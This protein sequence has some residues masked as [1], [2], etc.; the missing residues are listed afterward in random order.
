MKKLIDVIRE[1]EASKVAVGHFNISNLE[2]FWAVVNGAK[3]LN[4]PVI[5]GV[6]EGERDFMGVKQVKALVGTLQ[7]VGREVYLNADHT[8][9]FDRVKEVLDLGYNAAIIDGA[10]KSFEE[11]I[12]MTKACI[13]YKNS[14][15][16]E[17]L[18]EAELGFIG[19]S[20]QLLDE[21]P[22]GAQVNDEMMTKPEEAA[23][24]VQETG[25]DL[26]AP[27]VGNVHG[28]V[29]SGLEPRLNIDRIREIRAAAGVPLVLHGASGNS[30]E[31]ISAAIDAGISV[32]H[33][34]TEVRL[35][36]KQGLQKFLLDNPD[37][38]A[39]YKYL[40]AARQE[41]QSVVEKKL[42]LFNKIKS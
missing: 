10:D 9:S 27:A 38:I 32:I 4:V 39:P 36:F 20:S 18:V 7:D 40:K 29:K 33:I 42:K 22:E 28:M 8:Y 37:E 11:N 23:R 15:H 6:S 19:K 3:N 34:N 35:G 2:G 14:N 31:D 21:I 30:D 1:A 12:K 5:I 41:M 24:F 13:D 26:F 25:I 16:P 17:A